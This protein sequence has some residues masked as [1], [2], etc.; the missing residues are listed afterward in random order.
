[1]LDTNAAMANN[2]D[3][4]Q[5]SCWGD[6][7]ND[8]YQDLFLA[9]RGRTNLL[10]K[11]NGNGT[12]TSV[13]AGALTTNNGLPGSAIWGDFDN[14]GFLDLYLARVSSSNNSNILYRNNGNGTFNATTAGSLGSESYSTEGCN[15][16]DFNNDGFLDIMN[17]NRFS[18]PI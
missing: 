12:F 10:Y 17:A 8:G 15:M 11:N 3:S 2:A 13:S 4:V 9:R 16:G 1:T 5:T 18:K 6:Y 7:N 14:D